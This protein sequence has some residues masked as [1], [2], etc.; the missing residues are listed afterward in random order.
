[1]VYEFFQQVKKTRFVVQSTR[2]SPMESQDAQLLDGR[3]SESANNTPAQHSTTNATGE[4]D[5]HR[6]ID[7]M[8]LSRNDEGSAG[9]VVYGVVLLG[10]RRILFGGQ[11][12]RGAMAIRLWCLFTIK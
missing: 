8:Y 12:H 5:L 3:V 11:Q 4:K 9:I 7:L 2:I 10:A 1:V 6:S